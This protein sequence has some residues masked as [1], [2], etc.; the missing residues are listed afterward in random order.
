MAGEAGLGSAALYLKTNNDQFGRGLDDAQRRMMGF[1]TSVGSGFSVFA[2]GLQGLALGVGVN[3]G[4]DLVDGL[5]ASFKRLDDIQDTAQL[6]GT[7]A[8]SFST[9][10]FAA[11]ATGV[12]VE[13]LGQGLKKL[14]I[15]MSALNSGSE[16]AKRLFA[17]I[18]LSAEELQ[19]MPI[20]FVVQKIAT[21]LEKINNPVDRAAA[22]ISIFGKKAGPE[23]VQMLAV[24][25]K[26]IADLREE[27][28][29]LGV[30][31][32]DNDLN[33]VDQAAT[34]WRKVHMVM[35]SFMDRLAIGLS[36]VIQEAADGVLLLAEGF[37]TAA[38]ESETW[39][40]ATISGVGNMEASML[41]FAGGMSFLLTPFGNNLNEAFRRFAEGIDRGANSI[42]N[43]Q[44]K[45]LTP[46]VDQS[47]IQL[48]V[49][50]AELAEKWQLAMSTYGKTSEQVEA[51]RLKEKGLSDALYEQLDA[52]ARQ[53]HYMDE[54]FALVNGADAFEK[55]HEQVRGLN[56]L[57]VSG[58]V[59]A[60]QYAA[61]INKAAKGLIDATGV[62][63]VRNADI[64][65][66]GSQE[67]N[68]LVIAHRTGQTDP[69][70]QLKAALDAQTEIEKQQLDTAEK[71][72]DVLAQRGDFMIL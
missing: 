6:I 68:R 65:T 8:E 2:T 46:H 59:N 25:G 45:Q 16:D 56:L 39:V 57:F 37:A 63:Q 10:R 29:K 48:A 1:M 3:L 66:M 27:A 35:Q 13:A 61:A 53:K 24:G 60:H 26:G 15:Q 67:A 20:D 28:K 22:T 51:L 19:G 72:L 41:R 40:N 69:G 32:S 58:T 47:A 17:N 44:A 12:P 42:Q 7:T 50:A 38:K 14:T 31:M 4:H 11:I 9:L 71:I 18:G 52:L 5:Q 43:K 64:A 36:P 33:K 55:I 34:A 30:T 49:Q 62:G 54:G 23:L 21:S 70:A